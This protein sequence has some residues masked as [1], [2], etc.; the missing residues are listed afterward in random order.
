VVQSKKAEV[1]PAGWLDVDPGVQLQ[2]NIF[3]TDRT[4]WSENPD[5]LLKYYERSVKQ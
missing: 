3:Y 2:H 5:K 1:I 4:P